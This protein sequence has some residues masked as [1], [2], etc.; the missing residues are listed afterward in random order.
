MGSLPSRKGGVKVHT[1]LNN[2]TLLPEFMVM[3]NAKVHDVKAEKVK[4]FSKY[5][6]IAS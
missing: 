4:C 2:D 3:T 1:L 5:H 6:L